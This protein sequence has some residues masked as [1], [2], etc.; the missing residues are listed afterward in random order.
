MDGHE[1]EQPRAPA[2]ADQDL[3]VVQLLQVT[4]DRDAG[5]RV[6]LGTPRIGTAHEIAPGVVVLLE[7]L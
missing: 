4:V 1:R 7:E 6:W 3:L 5:G 2:P